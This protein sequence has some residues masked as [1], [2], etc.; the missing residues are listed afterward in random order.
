MI[1]H[2]LGYPYLMTVQGLYAWYK[3]KISLPAYDRFIERLER[4]SL[5]RAPVVTT[6]S[7]FAVDF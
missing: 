7:N 2:R 6:E 5:P 3:E 1:A 4:I